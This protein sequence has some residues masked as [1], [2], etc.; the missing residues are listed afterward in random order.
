M[1]TKCSLRAQ[2]LHASG[3]VR[4]LCLFGA[5]EKLEKVVEYDSVYNV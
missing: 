5:G 3:L 4:C 2:C 1:L